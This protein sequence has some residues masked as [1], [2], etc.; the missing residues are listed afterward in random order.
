MYIGLDQTRTLPFLLSDQGAGG[1]GHDPPCAPLAT[2]VNPIT[3][4]LCILPSVEQSVPRTEGSLNTPNKTFPP[5]APN[6]TFPLAPPSI[7]KQVLAI[8]P[9]QVTHIA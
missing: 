5:F 9:F 6:W 2:P 1:G 3:Q 7:T 8:Q 4:C